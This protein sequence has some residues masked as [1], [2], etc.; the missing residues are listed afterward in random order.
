M[1]LGIA[2]CFQHQSEVGGV[3]EWKPPRRSPPGFLM[4]PRFRKPPNRGGRWG[5][6]R[7]R[8]CAGGGGGCAAFARSVRRRPRAAPA[9]GGRC[10]WGQRGC[11]VI[12]STLHSGSS[13]ESDTFC[14]LCFVSIGRRSGYCCGEPLLF[15]C[16]A[17]Q[18]FPRSLL[19]KFSGALS[20][21]SFCSSCR[22]SSWKP[23]EKTERCCSISRKQLG[24]LGGLRRCLLI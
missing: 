7:P 13:H 20:P 24:L 18:L 15:L 11:C 19:P 2:V 10:A 17:G 14:L 5:H 9:P 22:L 6:R 12:L 4:L 16:S 21:P 3:L 1:D 8:G 23:K